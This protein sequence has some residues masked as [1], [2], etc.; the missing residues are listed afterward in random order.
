M[1]EFNV[2]SDLLLLPFS[3][4]LVQ[5][6]IAQLNPCSDA[7]CYSSSQTTGLNTLKLQEVPLPEKLQRK[8]QSLHFWK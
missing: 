5:D 3:E 1:I 4:I 8:F 6:I 2:P 7:R